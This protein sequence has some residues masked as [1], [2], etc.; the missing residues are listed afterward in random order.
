[1]NTRIKKNPAIS[2][3]QPTDTV[4]VDRICKNYEQL[5]LKTPMGGLFSANLK[6][7]QERGCLRILAHQP[8]KHCKKT[9]YCQRDDY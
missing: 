5:L 1:M 2:K 9:T 3:P 4:L 6:D 8:K 7:Q